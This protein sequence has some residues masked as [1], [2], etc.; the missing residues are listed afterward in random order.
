M[1]KSSRGFG[2][3]E[4]MVA[5]VLGLVVSMGIIQIFSA[6]RGTFLTQNAS[7]RMQEDAR[8]VLSKLMQEIRMTGMYGCLGF[9][10]YVP[11]A[12]AIA[13]PAALD[14]PILWDNANKTLTL[15]TSDIGTT[16]S[17]PTWTIV[18]DCQTSTQLYA[19]ARA[20]AAGQTAFP[21]RQLVYTLT[22]QNLTIKYGT[23]G[24][25]QPLLQNVSA[26]DVSFGIAGNPMTYTSTISA[27]NAPDI[28]SVRISLTLQDPD[29]RVRN[30]QYNVVAY[31]R[32]R[33]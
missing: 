26:F 1:K 24:T 7:A 9:S 21:M 23:G 3:I 20:P 27:A 13:W 31:L 17:S 15:V 33:F 16:G 19:G 25:A 6:S 32:N 11:T 28:R 5:L 22:G 8:F 4:I 30:Q 12:P 2:L 14:N 10:N 18:S 29:G